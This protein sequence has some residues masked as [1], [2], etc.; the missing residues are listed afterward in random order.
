[1]RY[2]WNPSMWSGVTSLNITGGHEP[3]VRYCVNCRATRKLDRIDSSAF[4]PA[5]GAVRRANA[6]ANPR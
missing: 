4:N 3:V 2:A 6:M 1:L 5:P